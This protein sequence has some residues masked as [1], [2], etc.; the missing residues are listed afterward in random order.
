MKATLFDLFTSKKFLAAATAAIVYVAGRFGFDVDT[1]T[2]DRVFV[3]LLAY[4]GAQGIADHGKG[5]AEVHVSSWRAPGAAPFG[6]EIGAVPVNRSVQSGRASPLALGLI[7]MAGIALFAAAGG[8]ARARPV[9]AAGVVAF[10]NC[11]LVHVDVQALADGK[12]F[13][14]A[15]INHLIAGTGA[16]PSTDALAVDLVPIRDDA[17]RCA[18]AAA[19]A[20]VTTAIAP[21]SS[22]AAPAVAARS[23]AT[24]EAADLRAR[25]AA[26]TR[27]AGW[28]A[29]R[30]ADGQVL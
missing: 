4:V 26:A 10:L 2:L 22:G 18:V 12:A 3:A 21:S 8:C 15:E 16:T 7:A 24:P 13:V 1:A 17:G 6:L 27:R 9:A 19:I 5:A 23:S 20:A 14:T 28:P 25:L 30:L 11:E 29:V